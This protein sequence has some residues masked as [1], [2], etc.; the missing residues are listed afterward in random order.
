MHNNRYVPTKL[1]LHFQVRWGIL[2]QNLNNFI[3]S[4][5]LAILVRS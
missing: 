4:L 5:Q 3:G 1:L 2:Y